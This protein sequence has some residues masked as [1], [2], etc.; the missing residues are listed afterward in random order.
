MRRNEAR[1]QGPSTERFRCPGRVAAAVLLA[2][3]LLLPAATPVAAQPY[4]VWSATFTA[5][6]KTV[7][8]V[9][10]IGCDDASALD[11]C[12]TAI[13]NNRFQFEGKE[14]TVQAVDNFDN[15]GRKVYV[16]LSNSAA[17]R[18]VRSAHRREPVHVQSDW[19]SDT[20]PGF[21]DS[22]PDVDRQP[23]GHG[24]SGVGG[25]Y[26]PPHPP[27]RCCRSSCQRGDRNNAGFQRVM[28]RRGQRPGDGLH[29]GGDQEVRS[30]GEVQDELHPRRTV[31]ACTRRRQSR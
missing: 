31:P 30:V 29:P 1:A 7:S 15:S 19:I 23:V 24:E 28:R 27:R 6:Q 20:T 21:R 4:T 25:A 2:C 13:T 17:A 22:R 26:S 3:A 5:D 8:S 9:V 14:Y 12:S 11:N 18:Y 10:R 16:R